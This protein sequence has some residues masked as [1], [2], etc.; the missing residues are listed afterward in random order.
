MTIAM[1]SVVAPD[2]CRVSQGLGALGLQ[3]TRGS[4]EVGPH[5]WMCGHDVHHGHLTGEHGFDGGR[6]RSSEF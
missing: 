3:T 5:S 2:S 6:Q 1:S 4:E